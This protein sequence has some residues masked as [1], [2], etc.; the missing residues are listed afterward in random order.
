MSPA[1]TPSPRGVLPPILQARWTPHP[2]TAHG[3]TPR[4]RPEA[5][6]FVPASKELT[7]TSVAGFRGGCG[8]VAMSFGRD[9]GLSP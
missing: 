6:A 8:G 3:Q 2:T 1:R 9:A 7:A 4:A 5:L